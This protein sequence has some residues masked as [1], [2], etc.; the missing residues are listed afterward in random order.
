[1]SE[2][3]DDQELIPV[4][5]VGG[6]YWT[7]GDRPG[8]EPVS[9][10]DDEEQL[11]ALTAAW[12]DD[13]TVWLEARLD[14]VGEDQTTWL[15]GEYPIWEGMPTPIFDWTPMERLL[16]AVGLSP[17]SPS[18]TNTDSGPDRLLRAL[19][20][21]YNRGAFG[22]ARDVLD[23]EALLGPLLAAPDRRITA[24]PTAGFIPG[25]LRPRQRDVAWYT[26][27]HATVAVLGRVVMLLRLPNSACPA[28]ARRPPIDPEER[29]ACIP[30]LERFL[31]MQ[32]MATG[33]EIAEAFG[34]RQATT[35][36]AIAAGIRRDLKDHE[37]VATALNADDDERKE[38]PGKWEGMP[39]ARLRREAAI[40]VAEIDGIAEISQLLDRNLATI[41]RRCGGAM[42]EI[43][44]VASEL[45]PPEVN[46]R[47]R[48]ALENVHALHN[49]CRLSA[50]ALRQALASYEQSQREHFQFIAALLASI[51]LIPTLIAGVFGTNLELPAQHDPTGFPIFLAVLAGLALV[52]YVAVRNA[53]KHDWEPPPWNLR[54]ALLAV[55]LILSAFAAYLMSSDTPAEPRRGRLDQTTNL[56]SCCMTVPSTSILPPS[57]RSQTRSVWTADSLTPPDSG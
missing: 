50:Q 24:F 5:P 41:A 48:F 21:A 17:P 53:R 46:R 47:Y 1:M 34:M 23:E 57:R 22:T 51:V 16:G 33:R 3:A 37:E 31:P 38:G 44:E 10:P 29:L 35:A 39:R 45:V 25:E 2:L 13:R 19:P 56:P 43:A 54:L 55:L 6:A 52:G 11:A 4:C 8:F 18:R 32:R 26:V 49:D 7:T 15:E 40:A 36:R 9:D 27:V 12:T 42:P 14:E 30:L 20:Y 28:E